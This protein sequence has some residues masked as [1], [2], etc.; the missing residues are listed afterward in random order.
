[1]TGEPISDDEF[2]ERAYRQKG[3]L[4]ELY[5]ERDMSLSEVG[6]LLGCDTKTVQRW[7]IKHDLE[8][9]TDPKYPQLEDTDWLR[10]KYKNEGL[11][12]YDIGDELGCSPSYVGAK[13]REA[14]I[15]R[16]SRGYGKKTDH[17]T[18]D[19]S[20]SYVRVTSH[21][22]DGEGGQITES[23]R[24]HR[25]LAVS[26]YGFDEV[27]GMDVHHKNGIPWDNRPENIELIEHGEHSRA[28]NLRETDSWD[29]DPYESQRRS[30]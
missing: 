26:E 27:C 10:E 21:S 11:T 22:P 15:E 29:R 23:I 18:F 24:L 1:M 12:T 7:M 2:G 3:V 16:H 13:L 19:F 25:L 8:R 6:D 28:H 30:D 5:Y 14:G 9:D 4:I 20:H 17:P